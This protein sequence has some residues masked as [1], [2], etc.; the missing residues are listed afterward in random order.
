MTVISDIDH[1]WPDAIVDI[2]RIELIDHFWGI[3]GSIPYDGHVVLA[4]IGGP[5]TPSTRRALRP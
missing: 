3:V 1:T 2:G 4:V 5:P